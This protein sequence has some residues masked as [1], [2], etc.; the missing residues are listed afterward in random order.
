MKKEI[1]LKHLHTKPFFLAPMAGITDSPFR[2]FMKE[3]GCGIVTTELVSAK[4]LQI[5]NKMSERL[6][7]FDDLQRPVGVQIFGEE[8]TALSDGAKIA[9]QTGADFIDLNFGCPVTKIIKKGA[10]SAALKDLPFLRKILQAVKKSISIPLS[11]K[12][13]TGWDQHSRNTEEVTKIAHEEGIIWITIHGRTRTQAYSGVADWNYIKEIKKQSLLPVIGN[14]DL[15][16]TKQIIKLKEESECDGMMIGRGCLKNPWLFQQ[17]S[18]PSPQKKLE[19]SY[20]FILNRL[21][22]YLE[23]FYEEKMFL[24]QYKKLS[25]WYSSGYP[26]SSRFRQQV[27]QSRDRKETLEL[28]ENYF[29]DIDF[30]NQQETAYEPALM[31]GHG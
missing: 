10:G 23:N 19:K 31:Q 26:E 1:L 16:E 30:K 4:S 11:I 7:A 27:F 8:L 25:T 12:V 28:I 3:M 18:T 21:K 20:I 15:T 6:M 17:V 22:H 29:R 2:S 5:G 13:R 9:E 24:L 14:G